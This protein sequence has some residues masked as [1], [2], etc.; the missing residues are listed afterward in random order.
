MPMNTALVPMSLSKTSSSRAT[1]QTDRDGAEVAAPGQ[2]DAEH[3][4]PG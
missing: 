4:L 1:S 2:V 3:P